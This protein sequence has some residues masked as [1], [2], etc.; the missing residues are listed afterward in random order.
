MYRLLHTTILQLLQDTLVMSV[1]E[2]AM[3]LEDEHA[4][5]T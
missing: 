1:M 2:P 5:T 4:M 3:T